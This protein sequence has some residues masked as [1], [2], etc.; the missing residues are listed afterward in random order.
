MNLSLLLGKS[1][2]QSSSLTYV[3]IYKLEVGKKIFK[4]LAI[5]LGEE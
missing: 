3:Q 5:L 2:N 4:D 1:F